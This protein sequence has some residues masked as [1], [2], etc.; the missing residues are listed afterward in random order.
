ML[1]G[2]IYQTLL[3]ICVRS[4]FNHPEIVF[5]IVDKKQIKSLNINPIVAIVEHI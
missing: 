2:A 5:I 4:Q 3:L 1:A